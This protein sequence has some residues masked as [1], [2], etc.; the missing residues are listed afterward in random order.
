MD[1][2][3]SDALSLFDLQDGPTDTSPERG[4]VSH[5]EEAYGGCHRRMF[6]IGVSPP[7]MSTS[8]LAPFFFSMTSHAR[9]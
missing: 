4:C 5:A 8:M 3:L 1:Y 9:S 6:H 2:G 7:P